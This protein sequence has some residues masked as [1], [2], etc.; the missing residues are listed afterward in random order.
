MIIDQI[1]PKV[2]RATVPADMGR[3]GSRPYVSA[4]S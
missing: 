2:G 1:G 4:R 3:H